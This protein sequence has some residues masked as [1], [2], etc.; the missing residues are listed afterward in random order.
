MGI[1]ISSRVACKPT[2]QARDYSHTIK[3][4]YYN[5]IMLTE[6]NKEKSNGLIMLPSD[7]SGLPY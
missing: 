6:R 1:H 2:A 4:T 5:Y 7:K 3:E